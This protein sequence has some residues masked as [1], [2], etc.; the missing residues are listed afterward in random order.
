M[1]FVEMQLVCLQL[2]KSYNYVMASFVKT[3]FKFQL[4]LCYYNYV[5]IA[6]IKISDTETI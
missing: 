4:T 1:T 3:D 6:E 5:D 2:A